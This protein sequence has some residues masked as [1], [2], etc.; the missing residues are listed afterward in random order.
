MATKTNKKNLI[1][2]RVSVLVAQITKKVGSKSTKTNVYSY[3]RKAT[4][5]FFGFKVA[6]AVSTPASKTGTKKVAQLV[7]GSVGSGS[8]KVP[9]PKNTKDKTKAQKYR[10]IPIPAGVGLVQIQSFL[11]K[12]TKNKPESFVSKDGRTYPVV[13]GK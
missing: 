5:E 6:N 3:M 2:P 11:K 9:V 4:A 7:R 8:I 12:A 13:K 1:G 10:Q